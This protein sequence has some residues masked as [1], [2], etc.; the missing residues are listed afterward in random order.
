MRKKR[1]KKAIR[2]A[3]VAAGLRRRGGGLVPAALQGARLAPG[4]DPRHL[5]E[6]PGVQHYVPLSDPRMVKLADTHWPPDQLVLGLAVDD[7]A[8]AYPLS[9]LHKHHLLKDRVNGQP[10]LV[11]YCRN[12]SSGTG[13]VPVVDDRELTFELFGVYQGS[14]TMTDSQTGSVWAQLTGR[15]LA[16]PLAGRSLEQLPIQTS[17]IGGWLELH[18]DSLVAASSVNGKQLRLGTAR[19]RPAWLD[20]VSH[21]DDRLPI[22][23]LVLGVHLAEQAR[24]YRLASEA[25]DVTIYQDELAG[26]PIVLLGPEGSWP[27]AYDRRTASG[28]LDLQP[29]EGRLVDQNGFEWSLEGRALS[30]PLSGTRLDF[31]PS[32]VTEWYAWAA[33]HPHTELVP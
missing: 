12:C 24:G 17:T 18:P 32:H 33:N 8:R 10:V 2:R 22:R 1:I 27:L 23:A 20:S 21:R 14:F 31:V 29:E 11:V 16:G 7:E 3:A 5:L 13:F 26:V 15:A 30:G 28:V 19:F 9:L 4:V 6:K 25:P